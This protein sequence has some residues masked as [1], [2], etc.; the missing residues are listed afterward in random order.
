[1][2]Q[3]ENN[4]HFIA[5]IISEDL[6]AG[7]FPQGIQTRFPP[8][9]NGYLHIGH[10]KSIC[11]NFGLAQKFS[12]KC[13][14]R[15]D[16]TNPEKESIEY[17]ESIKEDVAWL[18]FQWD[19]ECYASDYFE[20]LYEW[21]QQLIQKGLAYVCDLSAEELRKYRGTLTEPGRNSPFRERSVAENLKLFAAMRAGEFADG[22]KILR[23]KISMS[24]PNLN[25]RDP[26]LYRI[27]HAHHQ[28]SGDAW[29]IYP[30][31]DFT[32]GQ[33]DSLE[34]VTHSLCTLEFED[35]RP[36]YNWFI[37]QL[38]IFP[39]RQIEFARLNLTY[40]VMSKRKLLQLVEDGH[41]EGW[42]D[43]RMPT[44]C[45]MR[46]R[47]YTPRAIRDFCET[48]GI[49]KFNATTDIALLEHAVRADLNRIA[50]RRMVVFDP[51]KVVLTNYPADLT[52][53]VEG[54]NNPEDPDAGSRKIPFTQT[55]YIERN[56]FMED[57][58][59]KYFRLAPGM[60]VRLRYAYVI[61][62]DKV[63]KDK[64]GCVAE[65]HCHCDMETL[66]KAPEGRKVKGVIHWVCASEA[67]AITVRQF[68]RLFNSESPGKDKD[69]DFLVDLNANSATVSKALAEPA[70]FASTTDT[71]FQFERIGYFVTDMKLSST[72]NPVFNRTV[73][74]R[75]SWTKNMTSADTAG[76]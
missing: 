52:E 47:G 25:M 49:T 45:G 30:T 70:L 2:Q 34:G 65:L 63:I 74:L 10:A 13:N 71:I 66:G 20:Q 50:K 12:G 55:L 37:E 44:I 57:A 58:P 36:L 64:N 23:A 29:C 51:L 16:D 41:V 39:S 15:F 19:R 38:E 27:K 32:H 9:P 54:A 42:D 1:M 69:G 62:C 11:L 14:L 46:R 68:D 17:T 53:T 22:E 40:S 61:R 73:G 4:Q 8:E 35:H 56:D 75:D 59:K 60:E 67:K 76:A 7:K 6:A 31:Y 5:R 43:P 3:P 33:S 24:H 72:D 21:A 18:G 26:A 48:I 28:R